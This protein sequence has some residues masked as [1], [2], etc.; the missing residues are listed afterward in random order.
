MTGGPPVPTRQEPSPDDDSNRGLPPVETL[1]AAWGSFELA[2][3][4][5]KA[6]W[7]LCRS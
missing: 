4:P 1:S 5:G 6:V 3:K 2:N 7:A